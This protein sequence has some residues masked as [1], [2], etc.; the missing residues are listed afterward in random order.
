MQIM[1][2]VA[3]TEAVE[4]QEAVDDIEVANVQDHSTCDSHIQ[5]SRYRPACAHLCMLL[6]CTSE[7]K[8]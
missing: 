1:D 7:I 6:S 2:M 3:D 8:K 4:V 5:P